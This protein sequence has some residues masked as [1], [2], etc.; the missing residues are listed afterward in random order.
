MHNSDRLY[1]SK[2]L[3]NAD[4]DSFSEE[5][6]FQDLE[7]DGEINHILDATDFD[8]MDDCFLDKD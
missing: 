8:E 1:L 2:F 5:E 3:L 6:Y 4:Y 7:F